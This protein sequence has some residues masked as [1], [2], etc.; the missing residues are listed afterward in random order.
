MDI[1]GLLNQT[2][3]IETRAAIGTGGLV[4]FNAGVVYPARVEYKSKMYRY[5]N[6]TDKVST[7]RVYLDGAVSI[8]VTDRITMPDGTQPEIIEIRPEFGGS[9]NLDFKVVFV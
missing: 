9:G 7:A 2:V 8:A 6:G 3:T 4:T 1:S 5:V